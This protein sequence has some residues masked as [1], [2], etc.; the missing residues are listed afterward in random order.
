MLL[1]INIIIL[2]VINYSMLNFK[3][4]KESYMLLGIILSTIV[5]L[6]LDK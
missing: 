1:S 2:L 6:I 3:E 4:L 5:L